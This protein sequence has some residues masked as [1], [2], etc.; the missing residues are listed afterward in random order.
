MVGPGVT[1]IPLIFDVHVNIAAGISSAIAG[2]GL[3]GFPYMFDFLI[4][5]FGWRYSM[6]ILSCILLQGVVMAAMVFPSELRRSKQPQLS[7]N[8]TMC[9]DIFSWPAILLYV[10]TF[11]GFCPALIFSILV[12]DHALSCGLTVLDGSL[13]LATAGVG[14]FIGRLGC[15][16]VGNY[17]KGLS[18]LLIMLSFSSRT[19][20]I[21]LPMITTFWP[22]AA[23]AFVVGIGWGVHASVFATSIAEV[24]GLRLMPHIV[25]ITFLMIGLPPYVAL[26]FSGQ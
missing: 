4:S 9:R 19:L 14:N 7:S 16:L 3:I 26:P 8:V 12:P 18:V 23:V 11:L 17:T 2:I 13:V 5:H 25:G 20:M 10:S 21:F 1:V 22:M 24:F 6:V 15:G